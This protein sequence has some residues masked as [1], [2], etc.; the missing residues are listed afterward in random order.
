MCSIQV[1]YCARV[2]IN[3]IRIDDGWLSVIICFELY[4]HA[5]ERAQW[6][7][8]VATNYI[9][10]LSP[11]HY[12]GNYYCCSHRFVTCHWVILSYC[13]YRVFLVRFT[14]WDRIFPQKKRIVI[15]CFIIFDFSLFSRFCLG[16]NVWDFRLFH[17]ENVSEY[18]LLLCYIRDLSGSQNSLNTH[19]FA[20]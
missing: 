3:R 16:K 7:A 4:T 11:I 14:D 10:R 20:M 13:C 19:T 17:K 1:H 6:A 2:L 15:Q 8:T 18:Q 9:I 5:A 12:V